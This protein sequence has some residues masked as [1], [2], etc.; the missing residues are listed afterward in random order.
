MTNNLGL[1][2]VRMPIHATL[3]ISIAGDIAFEST[4]RLPQKMDRKVGRHDSVQHPG[5][6]TVRSRS[7]LYT[8]RPK[9]GIQYVF[10]ALRLE[11]ED[12]AMGQGPFGFS[13][14][15]WHR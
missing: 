4:L 3:P 1:G 11:E 5:P 2:M 8:L 12:D 9:V 15:R 14:R 13:L 10:R 7:S 6:P